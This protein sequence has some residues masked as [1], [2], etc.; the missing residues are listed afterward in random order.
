MDQECCL[1]LNLKNNTFACCVHSKLGKTSIYK[2]VQHIYLLHHMRLVPMP[3]SPRLV[4]WTCVLD[5]VE[6]ENNTGEG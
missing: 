3:L 1:G 4:S 5:K 6:E 2:K